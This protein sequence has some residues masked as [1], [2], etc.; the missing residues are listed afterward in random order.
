ML[1]IA[2]SLLP[3]LCKKLDGLEA[4][5]PFDDETG[6]RPIQQVHHALDQRGEKRLRRRV[7]QAKQEGKPLLIAFTGYACTNRH[8]MKANISRSLKYQ[9]H[10]RIM[11][12]SNCT[13]TAQMVYRHAIKNL[14]KITSRESHCVVRSWSA[15]MATSSRIKMA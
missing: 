4:F 1:A 11:C 14:S 7:G 5:L 8:W 15:G 13:R 9:P 12:Y 6:F 10:C 3:G 2:V